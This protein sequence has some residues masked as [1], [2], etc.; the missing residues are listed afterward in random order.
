[1]ILPEIISSFSDV[2]GREESE[3]LSA[4]SKCFLDDESVRLRQA[5]PVNYAIDIEQN[6]EF[7]IHEIYGIKMCCEYCE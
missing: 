4:I 5:P 6:E 3:F 7:N 2:D 1:M